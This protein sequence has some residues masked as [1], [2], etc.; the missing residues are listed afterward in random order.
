M[1]RNILDAENVEI[2]KLA[3]GGDIKQHMLRGGD[4]AESVALLL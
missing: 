4:V 3:A 1:T 2:Q